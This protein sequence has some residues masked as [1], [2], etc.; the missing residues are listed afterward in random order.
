[1]ATRRP[2]F[3]TSPHTYTRSQR[4][5]GSRITTAAD[6]TRFFS[7]LINALIMSAVMWAAVA[8]AVHLI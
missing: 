2:D 6:H 7:G 4:T 5:T 1:M 8:V 3:L